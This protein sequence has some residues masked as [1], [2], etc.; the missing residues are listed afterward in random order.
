[1]KKTFI[2]IFFLLSG[3]LLGSL[4]ASLCNSVPELSWLGYSQSIG[5][6]NINPLVLDLSI[7]T[8]TFGFK[9]AISVAQILFIGLAL[10]LYKKLIHGSK[11]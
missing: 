11:F 8:L 2:F 7:I 1:M 9:M 5:I 4:V 10:F 6:G 3:I